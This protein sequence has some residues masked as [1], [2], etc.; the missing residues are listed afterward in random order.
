MNQTRCTLRDCGKRFPA[1]EA[2]Y[3]GGVPMCRECREKIRQMCSLKGRGYG[4][5]EAIERAYRCEKRMKGQ[6]NR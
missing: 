5:G 2:R 6:E 4:T 3:L 1:S